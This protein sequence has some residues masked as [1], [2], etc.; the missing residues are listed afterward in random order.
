MQYGSS[1]PALIGA[2]AAAIAQELTTQQVSLLAAVLTQLGDSLSVIAA[3]REFEPAA[4]AQPGAPGQT[5][6]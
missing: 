5:P 4:N 2:L 1:L 3:A 6:E